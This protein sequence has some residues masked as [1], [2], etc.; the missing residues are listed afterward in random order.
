[1]LRFPRPPRSPAWLRA[2]T[3]PRRVSR[4]LDRLRPALAPAGV[5]A[6]TALLALGG[7]QH[8]W[9][10]AEHARAAAA[11]LSQAGAA[12]EADAVSAVATARDGAAIWVLA[13][14]LALALGAAALT[15][16]ARR[17]ARRLTTALDAALKSGGVPAERATVAGRVEALRRLSE[18]QMTQRAALD[19]ARFAE[20]IFDAEGRLLFAN[21]LFEELRTRYAEPYEAAVAEAAEPDSETPLFDYLRDSVL[22]NARGA[23]G[24]PRAVRLE[25]GEG[26]V[27]VRVSLALSDEGDKIGYYAEFVDVT[28]E[29]MLEGRI[30][31]LIDA[32]KNGDLYSRIR[33]DV[34]ESAVRNKF[35][36]NVANDLNQLLDVVAE[37]FADVDS[38][39]MA[40]VAGD[41]TFKLTGDYK[42]EFDNLKNSL[43][44]SM[45]TFEQTVIK[46]NAVASSV[47]TGTERIAEMADTLSRQAEA[48]S[49]TVSS[50]T[51]TL[52][53]VTESIRGNAENAESAQALSAE[54]ADRA[55]RGRA[56][57]DETAEAMDAIKT[58][59]SKIGEI[60]KLIEDI[61]MQTNLLALNAAIEAARAGEAGRG[62]AIVA[63]EVRNLAARSGDAAKTIHDLIKESEG[64]VANGARLF[65]QTAEALSA[66]VEAVS[67]TTARVA[68][69]TE[70]TKAE[71]DGADEMMRSVGSMADATGRNGE[72]ATANAETAAELKRQVEALREVVSFFIVSQTD[73]AAAA[74]AA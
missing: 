51:D 74:N 63:Q 26:R 58:G 49:E 46:I 37:L 52:N 25:W 59:T 17:S 41:V 4:A 1:M 16:V 39:V 22:A 44:E 12:G 11:A 31:H 2:V 61:A 13:G 32:F 55:N 6:L 21:R 64:R 30:S 54:T 57:L 33:L 18:R 43:N 24:E 23:N 69:I 67:Q 10:A 15:A 62:F 60:T 35:L 38:A 36:F 7:A 27:E 8:L 68:S 70:A 9:S 28:E 47:Q 42:G 53:G 40:M 72:I 45:T 66:I 29:A 34:D 73:E 56:L 14:G 5:F 50:A 19:G 65:D 48:Q 71:A 3:L 20:T